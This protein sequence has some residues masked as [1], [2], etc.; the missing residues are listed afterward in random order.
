MKLICEWFANGIMSP[1]T[2]TRTSFECNIFVEHQLSG[3][4]CYLIREVCHSY[5]I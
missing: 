5:L 3:N 4:L 1:V 2:V